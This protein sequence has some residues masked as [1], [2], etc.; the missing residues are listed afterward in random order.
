VQAGRRIWG[1]PPFATGVVA[2]MRTL[3]V[4]CCWVLKSGKA[5]D[6]ALAMPH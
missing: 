6:A 3:L 2:A 4:I 5:F 1:L